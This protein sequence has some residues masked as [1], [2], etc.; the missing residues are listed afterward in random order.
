MKA[1]NPSPTRAAE[2]LDARRLA[3]LGALRAI[4]VSDQVAREPAGGQPR[5]LLERSRLLE[6]VRGTGY[7]LQPLLHAKLIE[8]FLVHA[9]HGHVVAADDQERGRPD[10]GQGVARQVGA[11]AARDDRAHLTLCRRDQRRRRAGAGAEVADPQLLRVGVLLEPAGGAGE[12]LCEQPDVEAEVAGAQIGLFLVRR[13]EV[14]QQRRETRLPERPRDL[15][16]SGAVPT[17]TGAV[18]EEHDPSRALGHA[19]VPFE[20]D[21]TG[22]D[23]H[24]AFLLTE[25]GSHEQLDDLFVRGLGEVPVPETYRPEVRRRLQADELVHLGAEQ[26]GRLGGAHGRGEDEAPGFSLAER[27]NRS[28]GRHAGREAVVHQDH[29]SAPDVGLGPLAPEVAQP[30]LHLRRLPLR[31]SLQVIVGDAEAPHDVL[32]EDANAAGG[33]GAD[34]ELGLPRRPQL[35]RDEHLQRHPQSAGDLVPHRN[36]SPGEG[37]DYGA[38]VAVP[39]QP[40]GQ[41]AAGVLP[42][43]ERRL[44]VEQSKQPPQRAT[45]TLDHD[46]GPQARDSAPDPGPMRHFDDVGGVLVG[47][48]HLLV[49][50]GPARGAHEDSSVF[51]LPDQV[52][53]LRRLFGLLAAHLPTGAVGAGSKG[54]A[55]GPLRARQHEGVPAHVP[56]NQHRLA[57]GA[58]PG[59]QLLFAGTERPRGSLAVDQHLLTGVLLELGVVVREVVEYLQTLLLRVEADGGEGLPREVGDELPIGEGEVGRGGHGFEVGLSLRALYG[60][61]G[62]LPVHE[63]DA[64]P[65]GRLQKALDVFLADLVS[66]APGA[67]V[68]QDRDPTLPKTEGSCGLLV[69]DLVHVLHL[70]EV[71][72]RAQS[73]E[74]GDAPLVRPP[75]DR[76]GVRAR[77]PAAGLRVLEVLRL[78]ETSL[79]QR[80]GSFEEY[81]AQFFQVQPEVLAALAH[82]RRDRAEERVRQGALVP[83]QF[84]SVY[85]GRQEPHAAVDIETDA[86]RADHAALRVEGCDPAYREAVPPVD[87]GHGQ[88]RLDYPRQRRDVPEL[89]ERSVVFGFEVLQD[90]LR[91]VER[92]IDLHLPLAGDSV[93]VLTKALKVH[94][95]STGDYFTGSN[96]EYHPGVQAIIA[97][98][99]LQPVEG[100]AL[101][102]ALPPVLLRQ[103]GSAGEARSE[104]VTR[105]VGLLDLD[106][107]ARRDEP[108][109]LDQVVQLVQPAHEERLAVGGGEPDLLFLLALLRGTLEHD[110]EQS[111]SGFVEKML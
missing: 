51:Q 75:G 56:A 52:S 102:L 97:V 58:V 28:P 60:S 73:P 2:S 110:H 24:R 8:R 83:L 107:R 104:R 78:P 67:G 76:S 25:P 41:P 39:D 21:R 106:L 50:R 31:D 100:R 88:R 15:A 64:V 22:R 29:G 86:A 23:P 49:H 93:L 1:E 85:L 37:K 43:P 10:E 18:G 53:T 55:H 17:R 34:A 20:L 103:E 99:H 69:V 79:H 95:L 40:P 11:S 26:L 27:R 109:V 96:I 68:D 7:D 3:G 16:V 66:E 74:L 92:R 14:D 12:P 44:S 59:R 62:Q 87:V 81:L 42:V 54:L 4:S 105:L 108:G 111:L 30:A 57:H 70:E 61:G 80:G 89:P 47:L 9:D 91:G 63:L 94:D 72:A 71:V 38:L 33:D 45:S 5:D 84:F 19:Q 48:A 98:H 90:L 77:E 35:A 101:Y 65:R 82:P 32:V 6:E 36:P 13:E 46:Q